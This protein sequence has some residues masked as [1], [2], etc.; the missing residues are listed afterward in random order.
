LGPLSAKGNPLKALDRPAPWENFRAAVEA[1]VLIPDEVRNSSDFRKPLYAIAMPL[2]ALN[3][4]SDEQVEYRRHTVGRQ[5]KT[6]PATN[7]ARKQLSIR[8]K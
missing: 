8:T 7:H 1:V 5:T 2:Q 3:N 4:V 6:T